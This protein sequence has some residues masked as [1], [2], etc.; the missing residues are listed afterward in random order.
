MKNCNILKTY[1]LKISVLLRI[2][3]EKA[4]SKQVNSQKIIN[5][6]IKDVVFI[7]AKQIRLDLDLV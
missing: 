6:F 4:P 3:K 7:H 2:S 5:L 1:R